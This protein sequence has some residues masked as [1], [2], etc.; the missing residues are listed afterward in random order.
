MRASGREERGEVVS[1]LGLYTDLAGIG[2]L[3]QAI[4]K[5]SD[6][7]LLDSRVL[8]AHNRLKVPS[9]D[10]FASDALLHEQVSDPWVR[11]LTEVA[12]SARVPIVMGGHSLVAGGAWALSERVRSSASAAIG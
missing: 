4:E 11:E 8:F 3:I 12:A 1:M 6:A 10:R 2:G 7:A 5:T 9:H